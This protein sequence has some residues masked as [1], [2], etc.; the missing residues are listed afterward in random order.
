MANAGLVAQLA[1]LAGGWFDRSSAGGLRTS[2]SRCGRRTL[3]SMRSSEFRWVLAFTSTWSGSTS[4]GRVW[5]KLRCGLTE[6]DPVYFQDLWVLKLI[7]SPFLHPASVEKS[8]TW[9]WLAVILIR[10]QR[11]ITEPHQSPAL[12]RRA[13]TGNK[14]VSPSQSD[15]A[16]QD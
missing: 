4:P 10:A 16:L 8:W 6:T 9:L 5:R 15:P 14:P 3:W 12:R 11:L 7:S 13:V 1:W 2:R